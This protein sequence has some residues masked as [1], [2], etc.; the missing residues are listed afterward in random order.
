[1]ADELGIS[2]ASVGAIERGDRVP[3]LDVLTRLVTL[4]EPDEDSRADLLTQWLAKWVQRKVDSV[5]DDFSGKAL[6]ERAA[7]G[8][9]HALS[10]PQRSLPPA[11]P[12][13]LQG[14]PEQFQPL[15]GVFPDRREV[16]PD[17]PADLF[18]RSGA[19]TDV[20]YLPLLQGL[21]EPLTICSDKF[22]VLMP[23]DWLRRRFGGHHLLV[24]GSSGVN[25]LTRQLAARAL[26]RPLIGAK[27][28]AWDAEYRSHTELDDHRLLGPFWRLLEQAQYHDSRNIDPDEIPRRLLG[29][30]EIA[31]LARAA[32]L[33]QQIL[34]GETESAI[35]QHFRVPGFS[36]P[37]DGKQHGRLPG[38]N[39]DFGVISF[40]PHPFDDSGRYLSI[41]CAGISGPGTAHALKALFTEPDMFERHPFGGVIKVALPGREDWPGKFE[42]ADWR[43]QTD[44]YAPEDIEHNLKEALAADDPADRAEAFQGWEDDELRAALRFLDQLRQE[45]PTRA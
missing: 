42:K 6:L 33:A 44:P 21:T 15:I 38:D 19:V 27:W 1:V 20:Q 30:E 3:G 5:E 25:W 16:P 34:D 35:V 32:E 31:R 36:D 13:S 12:R 18:I 7:A 37:A 26:F 22:F 45:R 39:T 23:E 9:V 43:W 11:Y 29:A 17:S 8:L 41:I 14:F 28:R 24:V 10:G 2:Q 40:A 4:L